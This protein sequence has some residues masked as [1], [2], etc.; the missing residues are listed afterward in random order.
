MHF[1]WRKFFTEAYDPIRTIPNFLNKE[2]ENK[3]KFPLSEIRILL[4]E[5]WI[6]LPEEWF[7]LQGAWRGIRSKCTGLS[8]DKG[9]W[10]SMGRS[11]PDFPRLQFLQMFGYYFWRYE[12]EYRSHRVPHLCY[13]RFGVRGMIDEN[14]SR[15]YPVDFYGLFFTKF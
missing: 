11:G 8:L 2:L 9:V 14:Y 7:W 4:P 6:W 3:S 13:A 10:I 1:Q 15:W 5:A 12:I